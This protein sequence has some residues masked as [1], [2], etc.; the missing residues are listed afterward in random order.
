[1][2]VALHCPSNSATLGWEVLHAQLHELIAHSDGWDRMNYKPILV[3]Y[4]RPPELSWREGQKN[5]VR[6]EGDSLYHLKL[7]SEMT[8]PN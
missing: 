7:S 5:G 4:L 8:P 1:M 6:S 3:V 2:H